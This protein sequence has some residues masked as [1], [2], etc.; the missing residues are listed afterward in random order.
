MTWP[1]LLISLNARNYRLFFFGQFV[2][3]VGTWMTSTASLWLVYHL[4]SSAPMLGLVGFASQAP[5]FFCAPLAGVW[6]DR[7]NRHH[8]L[9]LTQTLSMLQSLTLAVLTFTHLINVDLLVGLTLLQGVINGVDMP[10]RQAMVMA[11][12]ERREHLSNAIALNSSSFNLARLIGPAIAGFVIVLVGAGGCFLVDGLSYLAVIVSLLVMRIE[13]PP[14]TSAPKH[15]LIEL[16]DGFHYTFGLKPVRA[17]MTTVALISFAGFSYTVLTPIYARDI[18]HGTAKTLGYLMSAIGVGAVIGATYLGSRTTVRG[19][20]SVIA[21]GGCLMGGGLAA[22]GFS[23]WLPLSMLAL[24]VVG[25]GG[26]LVMASSNT[27]L[28]TMTEE[29]KRGRVMS[30]FAMAFTGTMPIGNLVVGAATKRFGPS[31]VVVAAGGLSALVALNFYR[32][33]P[34]L[35]AAAA[36]LLLKVLP[37]EEPATR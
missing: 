32:Q 18:F 11:F 27:L 30:I 16:R 5:I 13:T 26:V 23:R 36:P 12:V 15:P 8:L 22:F 7:V 3:T 24:S 9:V 2:S 35:R 29:E 4:S 17:L 28:Q 34:A 25:L 6:V 14:R 33:L 21:I 37:P 31:P 10:T 19:L 20:G 1:Q